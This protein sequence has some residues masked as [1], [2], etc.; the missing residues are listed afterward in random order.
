MLRK[1]Q[2]CQIIF[3]LIFDEY[4]FE[5]EV[6][7][8]LNVCILNLHFLSCSTITFSIVNYYLSVTWNNF[9]KSRK[10]V[11]NAPENGCILETLKTQTDKTSSSS[12]NFHR[13]L[14]YE[15][16]ITP[17]FTQRIMWYIIKKLWHDSDLTFP[18][19]NR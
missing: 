7:G 18:W 10:R 14:F 17:L 8:G 2:L 12:E 15:K 16:F 9:W 4:N 19:K 3:I 5:K 13:P 11:F 1:R 6:G